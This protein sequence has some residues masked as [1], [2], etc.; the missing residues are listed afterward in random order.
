MR[1]RPVKILEQRWKEVLPSR[2]IP[3]GQLIREQKALKILERKNLYFSKRLTNLFGNP[4]LINHTGQWKITEQIFQ[5]RQKI[6]SL[7]ILYPSLWFGY[8]WSP[9]HSRSRGRSH[10]APLEG[11]SPSKVRPSRRQLGQ[12]AAPLGIDESCIQEVGQE[13]ANCSERLLYKESPV[14]PWTLASL[15][16]CVHTSYAHMLSHS[17]SLPEGPQSG[18][19]A[20][21]LGPSRP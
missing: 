1:V 11:R 13:W 7:K 10:V 4:L 9:R 14:P 3:Q 21:L 6:F 17:A 2:A 8:S 16:T 15:L 20:M 5:L 12:E 19:G 18:N